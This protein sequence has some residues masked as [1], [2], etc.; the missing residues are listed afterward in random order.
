MAP[1]AGGR[2]ADAPHHDG[3]ARYT[4]AGPYILGDHVRVTLRVP[5]ACSAERVRV[6]STPDAEPLL[7]DARVERTTAG[8]TWWTADLPLHNP[9][10]NYR[11]LLEGG[12]VGYAWCN[13]VGMSPHDVPDGGDFRL[14]V[15]AAAPSWL[16]ETV[17]YQIF[18]DRFA[19]S[20]ERRE[21]PDW[22]I[23]Q[24]WDDPLID[25]GERGPRQYFGGDLSGIEKHLDHIERLGV[26]LVYLTPFFPAG[27]THRYDA[28]TFEHVDPLLGGDGALVSLVE[29]AHRRGV[30]VVGDITLN[31]TGN[32]HT[33][34][35]TAQADLAS[36]EAG[37]YMFGDDP[38]DYV[39]WHDV[40]S[41]PKLDHRSSELAAR[42]HDGDR[43]VLG[44]FL[45]PPFDLDG[46]RVDCANTTAR[47]RDMDRNHDVARAARRTLDAVG[48]GRD[49]WLI[50]EHCYDAGSDL[51]GDGWHGVM[52]YQWFSRPIWSWLRGERP[53]ALM[54]QIDLPRLD[55]ATAV[56][57][58]RLLGSDV[59]W[60]ARVA[61]M[62]MIDSHDSA[63]FRT[64]VGGDRRR[65]AT[66]VAALM[67][68]PGVPTLFSGS[69]VGVEGDS[70]DTCRVPFPWDEQR[71][72][73]DLF[74]T[75]RELTALRRRD[76]P[77]QHGGMR[78]LDASPESITFVRETPDESTLVHLTRTDVGETEVPF[79]DLDADD[80]AEIDVLAGDARVDGA[81]LV[82]AGDAPATIVSIRRGG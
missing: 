11:F 17:G 15:G 67:T 66:G 55:G 58:M 74:D 33:W 57:A 25:G 26:N 51:D 52:A 70:M 49:R 20:G 80:G 65:H 27:T 71:W 30:R 76:R 72:D 75:T 36:D 82:V 79:V 42:L 32:H 44:R 54:G 46:W 34:F 2:L 53:F 38:D 9:V 62:T 45:R 68:M 23:P 28:S 77:L 18:L 81:S 5:H 16:G 73:R 6:R 35:R 50:A 37:F 69:E 47:Y 63:R 29:A 78:W 8:A 1:S 7:V 48:D 13:E 24:R 40:P 60:S 43:S 14:T 41:L 22:A 59:P 3:S 39:A 10:T 21:L 19:T 4:S 64:A 61:S 56:G 12:D 31:H